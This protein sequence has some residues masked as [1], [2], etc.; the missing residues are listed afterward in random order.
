[1][2]LRF[3]NHLNFS[4]LPGAALLTPV[5][6][7]SAT[8]QQL[9]WDWDS[10]HLD[11]KRESD[12]DRSLHGSGPFEVDRKVLKDVVRER[13]STDVARIKFLSA[14]NVFKFRIEFVIN[15]FMGVFQYRDIPQSIP[16]YLGR[17][18]R[19]SG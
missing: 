11:R 18:Q 16:R 19:S 15:V 9:E 6:I 1:M 4:T 12:A 2:H 13:T 8:K 5:A 14:G 3:A 10:E 7:E 17:W